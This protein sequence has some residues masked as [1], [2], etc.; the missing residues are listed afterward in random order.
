MGMYYIN[1]SKHYLNK[2]LCHVIDLK[3]SDQ[4][5]LNAPYGYLEEFE[6]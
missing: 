5:L 3:K 2:Y 4:A 6:L 1:S